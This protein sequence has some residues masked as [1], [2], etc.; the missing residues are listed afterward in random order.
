MADITGTANLSTCT[1][2]VDTKI[3]VYPGV[4]CPANGTALACNDDNCGVQSRV[5]LAV[6]AGTAY[7]VQVGV[8]PGAV[9]GVGNLDIGIIPPLTSDDCTSPSVIF[10]QGTFLYDNTIATT[11]VEGQSETACYFFGS[12]VID[13]DIWYTWT[14]NATGPATVETCGNTFLDTKLAAYPGAGC[15]TAGSALAC[16]DD[17][18]GLQ[19]SVTFD[20]TAGTSYT[21]QVGNF[22]GSSGGTGGITIT[23]VGP[24][25]VGVSFCAC[26]SGNSPCANDGAFGQGCANSQF[27]SGAKLIGSGTATVGFDTL[28]L[29]TTGLRGGQPGLYF[30]GNNAVGGGAGVFFSDGLRCVGQGVVRLGAVASDANGVSTTAGFSQPLSVLGGV[31]PGDM[32]HYQLWHRDPGAGVSPCGSGFNL[33]NGYTIQW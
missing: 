29:T 10:G 13:G 26:D 23:I 27:P 33:S 28:V 15:P 6:T 18:C 16:N 30:Q 19:S 9:G 7:T 11:G 4:G 25:E 17:S 22:P 3:A 20:A 32:R 14:A 12:T 21:L 8:S 31:T 2:S 1:S 24:P 5:Q